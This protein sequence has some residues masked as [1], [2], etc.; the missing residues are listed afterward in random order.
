MSPKTRTD[1]DNTPS[2]SNTEEDNK[3]PFF[4]AADRALEIVEAK[5]KF[6]QQKLISA[7]GAAPQSPKKSHIPSKLRRMHDHVDKV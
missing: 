2:T 3:V 5:R 4:A 7:F 6:Q 1:T